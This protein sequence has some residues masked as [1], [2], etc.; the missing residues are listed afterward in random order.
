MPKINWKQYAVKRVGDFLFPLSEEKED[1]LIEI[2]KELPIEWHATTPRKFE[3]QAGCF[4]CCTMCW[5][6]RE[7]RSKLPARYHSG[8]INEHSKQVNGKFFHKKG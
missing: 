2:V 8:L 7:E 5:F 6:N 3:C 1:S 4:S